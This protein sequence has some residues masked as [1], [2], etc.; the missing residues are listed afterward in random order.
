MIAFSSITYAQWESAVAADEMKLIWQLEGT[1]LA[2]MGILGSFRVMSA[3]LAA[4]GFREVHHKQP[5]FHGREASGTL[6]S[7]PFKYFICIY[8]WAINGLAIMLLC[9]TEIKPKLR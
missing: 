1:V 3:F 4:A 8:L 2:V 5:D 7:M 6:T 9:D